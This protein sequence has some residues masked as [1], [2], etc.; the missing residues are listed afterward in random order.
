MKIGYNIYFCDNCN[1]EFPS[2][3]HLRR[4]EKTT[5][6]K[7]KLESCKDIH[8]KYCN[9]YFSEE[10]Y[11]IHSER[12]ELFWKHKENSEYKFITDECSCNNFIFYE[13]RYAKYNYVVK[14]ANDWI[15]KW[16]PKCESYSDYLSSSE[17]SGSS[18]DDSS[19]NLQINVSFD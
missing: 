7:K 12:N 13:Q 19:A 17:S 6:H 2:I 16:R 8:C 3:T 18:D 11:K 1:V 4:H 14:E 9:N 5:K 15:K 10:G